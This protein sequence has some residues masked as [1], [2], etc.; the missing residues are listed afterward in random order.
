M[1]NIGQYHIAALSKTYTLHKPNMNTL[2]IITLH[3]PK[4]F[5]ESIRSAFIKFKDLFYIGNIR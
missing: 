1:Q 2:P 5:A 3:K 4:M